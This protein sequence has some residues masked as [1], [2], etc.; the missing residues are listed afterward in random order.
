VHESEKLSMFCFRCESSICSECEKSHDKS[1]G[2]KTLDEIYNFDIK[3]INEQIE[4]LT[5][6]C[7]DSIASIVG[8][9]SMIANL[10]NGTDEDV[11]LL[12]NHIIDAQ[13]R[14]EFV[15]EY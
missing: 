15:H 10:Q 12:F 6:R 9:D 13:N 2:L 7:N 4:L 1:H 8:I 5:G 14:I 3:H 11:G